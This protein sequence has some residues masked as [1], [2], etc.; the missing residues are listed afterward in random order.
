[1]AMNLSDLKKKNVH[2]PEVRVHMCIKTSDERFTPN[3]WIKPSLF[4]GIGIATTVIVFLL[5][6]YYIVILAWDV[7]YLGM[8]FSA[9][10]PWAHCNNTWNTWR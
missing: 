6:I 7:A 9:V 8:A 10:L 3:S 1:M 5:N 4:T 2:V